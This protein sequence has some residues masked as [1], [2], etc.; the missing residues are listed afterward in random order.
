[1]NRLTSGS[2]VVAFAALLGDRTQLI[3]GRSE[4][5]ALELKAAFDATLAELGGGRGGGTRILSGAAGSA[6]R[7]RVAAALE[8]ARAWIGGTG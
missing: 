3:F 2:G 5:L 8:S 6:D 4:G 7:D 1:M